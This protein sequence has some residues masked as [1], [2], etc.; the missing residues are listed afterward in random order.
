LGYAEMESVEPGLRF[1]TKSGLIVETT[2]VTQ[3]IEAVDILVHEV[4]IM[5]EPGK[6]NKF[7]HNLDFA[8]R[9]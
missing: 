7:L 9:L 4:E 1:K 3:H 8:E 6:G 5:E 2:G